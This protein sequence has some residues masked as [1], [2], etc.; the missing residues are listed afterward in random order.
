MT[1]KDKERKKWK[2]ILKYEKFFAPFDDDELDELLDSGEVKKYP[3]NEFII[4]EDN[5]DYTFFVILRGKVS[6]I[7]KTMAKTNRNIASLSKGDCFGEMAMLLDTPRFA[8]VLATIECVLFKI[9]GKE[10]E[11]M[12]MKTQLKLFRQFAIS[13]ARRLKEASETVSEQI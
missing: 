5:V 2:H 11:K 4:R 7:K 3:I 13:L 9:S 12:R 6:I 8:S 10:I 1:E